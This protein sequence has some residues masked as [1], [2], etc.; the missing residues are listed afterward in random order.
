MIRQKVCSE[1]E[2]L[3]LREDERIVR[4]ST[5]RDDVITV[6]EISGGRGVESQLSSTSQSRVVELLHRS[7]HIQLSVGVSRQNVWNSR[8][9]GCQTSEDIRRALLHL[10]TLGQPLGWRLRFC[11]KYRDS[12]CKFHSIQ[13]LRYL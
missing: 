12:W 9:K 4:H 13:L 6:K 5:R 1:V 8:R 11:C 3:L 10:S 2:V 7:A